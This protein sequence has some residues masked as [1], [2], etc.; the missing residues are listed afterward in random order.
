MA[1]NSVLYSSESEV[2]ETPK[3]LFDKLDTE[4]HFDID[5]CALP[6][7]S[8]CT[9]FFTPEQDGLKQKWEGVCWMN[10]PYGRKIGAWMRKALESNTTVVCLVPAR[11]DTKWWHDYAMK[12]SEIRF[13]KGRLKF[14]DSKNSAPFPSA[15]I[16]FRKKNNE[17]IKVTSFEKG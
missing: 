6:S 9:T 11:T 14:G 15:I 10:P 2:W 7:N 5:V 17:N 13:I 3:D 4:F 8:K 16:V 1:I 12:A